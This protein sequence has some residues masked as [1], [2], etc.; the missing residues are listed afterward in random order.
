MIM[1]D[2]EGD[3]QARTRRLV[4]RLKPSFADHSLMKYKAALQG[5]CKRAGCVL[6]NQ[7]PTLHP[8]ATGAG[9]CA[10]TDGTDNNASAAMVTCSP[11]SPLTHG[12]AYCRLLAVAGRAR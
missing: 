11:L 3:C 7:A 2:A 1:L 5:A 6:E 4:E 9:P 12:R 8:P 10:A